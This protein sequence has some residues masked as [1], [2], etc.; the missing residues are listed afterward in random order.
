MDLLQHIVIHLSH[1]PIQFLN[2]TCYSTIGQKFLV[3]HSKMCYYSCLNA[4][5]TKRFYLMSDEAPKVGTKKNSFSS[6]NEVE[7]ES[8]L[9]TNLEE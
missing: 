3:P 6:M 2:E 7:P 5:D 8:Q 4:K 1:L 9:V